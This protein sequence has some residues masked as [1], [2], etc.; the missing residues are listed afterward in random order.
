MSPSHKDFSDLVI[1]NLK[2]EDLEVVIRIDSYATGI[3]R[4]LYFERKFRRIFGEDSQLLLSL[5]AEIRGRVVGY[6]MGEANTG[7]YG[8]PETVASIDTIGVD[9]DY[10]GSSI[11]HMLLEDYCSMAA[12]VG[13]EVMTTLVSKDDQALIDFFKKYDFKSAPMVALERHLTAQDSNVG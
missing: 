5:V 12:K 8:I 7:E 6:I 2:Q 4:N 3:P 9:A 13:V 11:G 1:R 10:R